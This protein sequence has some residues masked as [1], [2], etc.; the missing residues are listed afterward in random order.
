MLRE[1]N[2]QRE[3]PFGSKNPDKIKAN[4]SN[5]KRNDRIKRKWCKSHN[6][7]LLEIPYWKLNSVE[8]CIIDFIHEL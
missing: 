7:P 8:R 5:T 6:I 3:V 1:L 2:I 4:F